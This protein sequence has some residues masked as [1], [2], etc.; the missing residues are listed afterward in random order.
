MA[1]GMTGDSMQAGKQLGFWMCTA[2]V[3]GNTIGVGIFML[4]ASL[5]PYGLNAMIGWGITVLGMTVL[6]RVFARL[7]RQFP[8][9]DGPFAY[10]EATSGRLAAF[11]SIWCYW[12][13]CWITNAA[14]AIG[15]VAYLAKVVPALETVPPALQAL[16]LLWLCIVVNLLGVRAGG[17]LQVATTL[18]K[19]L[20]LLAIVLLGAGLLVSEPSA[21]TAQVPDTPVAL[22][23][24]MA[25]S[26][27]ALFAML[28]IESAAVPAGRVHDPERTVPR[29]TMAGTL[30]TAAIYVAVSSMAIL[31]LPQQ[32]LAASS[33]P[34][35]DL[36]DVLLGQGHGRLLAVFVVISG[37]GALNGWTLLLGEL[38]ASMARHG[39]L[40][41]PLERL[42]GRG[43]PAVALLATG[44]LATATL[45]MNYSK[46]L[47]EGFTLL[48]LIVT[49]AN[50]PLYLFCALA[51]VVLWRRGA[52]GLPR[53][54][55]VLGLL[56]A[57]YSVFALIG[58]GREPFLWALAL[59]AAGLPL[60]FFSSRR[61]PADP[62]ATPQTEE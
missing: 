55:L 17:G 25:A 61:R 7:A 33:A 57:A 47:V 19:L 22:E 15:V 43:A 11:A 52:R 36:L 39:T 1:A 18:L 51:L 53:D 50:L 14:I 41:R 46:S 27:I 16:G 4:P 34:F 59:G 49:A 35:S 20:P 12:V 9:A 26:T 21:Y 37:L 42:N 24:L 56:G 28:G 40:P 5:A 44:V 48:T 13:Q 8:T 38:T 58:L 23:S 3:V 45:L 29:A 31:L 6:A 10:I 32:Q 60:Y 30:L 2:L 62:A 54:L